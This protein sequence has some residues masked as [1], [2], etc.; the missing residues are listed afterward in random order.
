M[1]LGTPWADAY[2]EPQQKQQSFV[3]FINQYPT[4]QNK[5]PGINPMGLGVP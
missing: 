2:L 5:I 1:G 4:I 3:V